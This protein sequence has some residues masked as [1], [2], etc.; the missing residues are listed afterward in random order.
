MAQS[1][2]RARLTISGVMAGVPAGTRITGSP[3]TASTR[4][5]VSPRRASSEM[6]EPSDRRSS[7]A[8]SLAAATTSSSIE[9]VVRTELMLSHQDITMQAAQHGTLDPSQRRERR[10]PGAT[11]EQHD[12]PRAGGG[13]RYALDGERDTA[14][15]RVGTVEGHPHADLITIETT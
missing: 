6:T 12:N 9:R 14:D 13:R 3:S 5:G 4:A 1:S 2:S 10:L 11:G 15:G 8:S 7:A